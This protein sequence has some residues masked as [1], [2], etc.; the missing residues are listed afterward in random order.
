M[1]HPDFA[2][3]TLLLLPAPQKWQ[4][5]VFLYLIFHNLSQ[6][7]MLVVS[8]GAVYLDSILKSRDITLPTKVH[9]VKAVVF[10]IIMYGCES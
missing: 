5:L 8:F 9:I 1:Q 2:L 6:L 4:F 7:H 10:P 3:D